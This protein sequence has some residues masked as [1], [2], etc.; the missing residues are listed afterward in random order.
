V[1]EPAAHK[2]K[3]HNP[4]L[5]K[6]NALIE[7]LPTDSPFQSVASRSEELRPI[8]APGLG[9]RYRRVRHLSDKLCETLE[10]EDYIIQTM[11]EASPTKWHLAH[12]SW[13]FETFVLKPFLPDYQS[14]HPEFAFLFNS[15]YNTVGP[16]YS[17]P[18]RGLLSRPTV[19]EVYHYRS[20]IDRLVSELIASAD[21]PLLSKLEALLTLGLH[22]EQQHQELMLTDIKNVFWQNPLR[23]VYRKRDA[24][25]ASP[26]PVNEW[27][28]F[29]EGIHWVRSS[30]TAVIAAPTSGFPKAGIQ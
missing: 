2:N 9:H 25:K 13:F 20:E 28:K 6:M 24:V 17:R 15:Y 27:L 12:T 14:A 16:F 11:P 8:L 26:V 29:H 1:P 4:G 21:E 18:H 5:N 30:T 23:P 7:T 3:T 10:P 19:R 22:H